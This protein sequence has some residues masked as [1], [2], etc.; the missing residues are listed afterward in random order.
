MEPIKLSKEN[1]KR[2]ETLKKKRSKT[3]QEKQELRILS[4]KIAKPEQE[5]RNNYTMLMR[6]RPAFQKK[7]N[8]YYPAKNNTGLYSKSLYTPN[9]LGIYQHPSDGRDILNENALRIPNN[10][11]PEPSAEENNVSE[12]A[13]GYVFGNVEKKPFIYESQADVELRTVPYLFGLWYK[14]T[15]GEDSP[16]ETIEEIPDELFDE[17]SGQLKSLKDNDNVYEILF[18]LS[19][20]KLTKFIEQ[21]EIGEE[22]ERVP[23][24]E[25]GGKE[26]KFVTKL[27]NT[28][29]NLPNGSSQIVTKI[30]V[31]GAIRPGRYTASMKEG[32]KYMVY[33]IDFNKYR[34]AIPLEEDT[35]KIKPLTTLKSKGCITIFNGKKNIMTYMGEGIDSSLF[36]KNWI[37]LRSEYSPFKNAFE[38]VLAFKLLD[39]S[40][41]VDAMNNWGIV[42]MDPFFFKLCQAKY[43]DILYRNSAYLVKDREFARFYEVVFRT[44]MMQNFLILDTKF[45]TKKYELTLENPFLKYEENDLHEAFIKTIEQSY[46]Y[47]MTP[48]MAYLWKKQNPL[49]WKKFLFEGTDPEKH[50]S[51][52]QQSIEQEM[53]LYTQLNPREKILVDYLQFIRF[54]EVLQEEYDFVKARHTYRD[55][56]SNPETQRELLELYTEGNSN[57]R[58]MIRYLQELVKSHMKPIESAMFYSRRRDIETILG[59][60]VIQIPTNS[61]AGP[62][63]VRPRRSESPV[64]S[65]RVPAPRRNEL[66][67]ILSRIQQLKNERSALL[68]NPIVFNV[69]STTRKNKAA[70][71]KQYANQLKRLGFFSRFT[72]AQQRKQLELNRAAAKKAFE[73]LNRLN[74]NIQELEQELARRYPR[75]PVSPVS[76]NNVAYPPPARTPLLPA[77]PG[78]SAG[79]ARS[80]NSSASLPPFPPAAEV[81]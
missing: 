34:C 17:L 43:P 55:L 10:T 7:F 18:G 1:Q 23:T 36:F 63:N 78:S 42:G 21:H 35:V 13:Q 73:G 28:R 26:R 51:R 69:A 20:D 15:T 5:H 4:G 56:L 44:N 25:I 41:F 67:Q 47:G 3:E 6:E 65:L 40:F 61:S 68:R 48:Y 45:Y 54:L 11:I 76:R 31:P 38:R 29:V 46:V 66:T 49:L 30:A 58:I 60:F 80:S 24:Q 59:K 8:Q 81:L 16:F 75:L 9:A 57:N 52:W 64:L 22:G 79:T 77:S 2:K 37:V 72:K 74:G 62:F 53:L 27:V 14:K 50:N 32:K 71:N 12:V 39:C 19:E 33:H 70:V